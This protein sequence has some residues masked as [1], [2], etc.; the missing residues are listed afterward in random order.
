[1]I[2]HGG[3][4]DTEQGEKYLNHQGTKSTKTVIARRARKKLPWCLSVLVVALPS[5]RPPANRLK[6]IS[7]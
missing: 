3:T 1:M 7:P 5:R 6:R 4:E 2:H